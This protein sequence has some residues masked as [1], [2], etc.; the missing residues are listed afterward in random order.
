MGPAPSRPSGLRGVLGNRHVI[1]ALLVAPLLA[2]IAYFAVDRVVG[3][4]PHAAKPDES[5]PLAARPECRWASGRCTLKNEEV[6]LVIAAMGQDFAL[7]A[8]IELQG[9]MYSLAKAGEEAAPQPMAWTEEGRWQAPL[10]AGGPKAL[11]GLQLRLVAATPQGTR[12]YGETGLKFMEPA[13]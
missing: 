10:P 12:F 2:L 7:T 4:R 6:E 5:Y 8:S 9:V 3:E 13:P 1:V 11:A